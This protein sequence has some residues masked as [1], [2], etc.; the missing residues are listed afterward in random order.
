MGRESENRILGL[1]AEGRILNYD[2]IAQQLEIDVT[3]QYETGAGNNPKR[4]KEGAGVKIFQLSGKLDKLVSQK[5]LFQGYR[6]SPEEGWRKWSVYA[7][8]EDYKNP[9]ALAKADS[10]IKN[11]YTGDRPRIPDKL[12]LKS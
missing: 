12:K 8:T 7:R 6:S 3:I 1:F 2:Q 4:L 11:I 10:N 9:K 5:A